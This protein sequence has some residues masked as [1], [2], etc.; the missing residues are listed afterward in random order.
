MHQPLYCAL[1]ATLCQSDQVQSC[2]NLRGELQELGAK[3][4]TCW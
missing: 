1:D 3:V 4:P 2:A